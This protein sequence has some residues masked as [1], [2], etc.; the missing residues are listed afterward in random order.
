MRQVRAAC[1]W[2]SVTVGILAAGCRSPGPTTATAYS[3]QAPVLVGPV[4]TLSGKPT[5]DWGASQG[6]I[7]VM[8]SN[9]ATNAGWMTTG[10][11]Y[12]GKSLRD[13]G[14]KCPKCPV[15][16]KKLRV[17]ASAGAA[18][19]TTVWAEGDLRTAPAKAGGAK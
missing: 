13:E 6:E 8:V 15:Q 17:Y 10:P 7:E 3:V 4:R 18:A 2:T 14:A 16:L 19:D 5:A 9:N 11:E 1:V 12:L